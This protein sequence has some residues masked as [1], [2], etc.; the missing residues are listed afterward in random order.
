[1]AIIAVNL[2]LRTF[3]DEYVHQQFADQFAPKN[4]RSVVKLQLV[5]APLAP[6]AYV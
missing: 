4:D 3:T 6:G 5:P 2:L 1:M